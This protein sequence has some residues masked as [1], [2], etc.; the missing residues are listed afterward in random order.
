MKRYLII[1]VCVILIAV[2]ISF[3]FILNKQKQDKIENNQ[4][5][6]EV[7]SMSSIYNYG[8]T[9]NV[10]TVKLNNGYEMPM[11]GIG[12]YSLHD[13]TCI[14]SIYTAIQYGYRKIDTAYI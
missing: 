14:N 10:P 11:I 1:S 2:F 4:G 9:Q 8:T 13:E 7:N 6:N 3:Y 12:T 5:V